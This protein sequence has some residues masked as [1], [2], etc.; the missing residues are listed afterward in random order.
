MFKTTES[1][2][3]TFSTRILKTTNVRNT[4]KLKAEVRVDAFTLR[5]GR[6]FGVHPVLEWSLF[7]N[8]EPL[9]SSVGGGSKARNPGS[10]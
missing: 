1:I 6:R 9:W 5:I 4:C 8:P 7:Q 10:P 2:K 3:T